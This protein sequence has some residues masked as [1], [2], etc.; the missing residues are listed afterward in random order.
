MSVGLS[1]AG[2]Y[3]LP[4]LWPCPH[5]LQRYAGRTFKDNRDENPSKEIYAA[6]TQ[7][8]EVRTSGRQCYHG[9]ETPP[10]R[11]GLQVRS[12]TPPSSL[13]NILST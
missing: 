10:L 12:P 11:L 9:R 2:E 7:L 4:H 13:R 1:M 3:P 8:R 5:D 6:L